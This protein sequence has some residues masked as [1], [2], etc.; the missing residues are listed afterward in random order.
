MK[1]HA[2]V[3]LATLLLTAPAVGQSRFAD[4]PDDERGYRSFPEERPA[5][6]EAQPSTFRLGLGPV[7]RV[8]DKAADGGLGAALDIGSRAAGARLAGDWVRVGSDQGL[9]QYTAELWVDF[10]SGQRL[11]PVLGAGAGIA[12]LDAENAAGKLEG[13]ALGIGVLRGTLEYVLPIAEA[14]ARAGL[15]VQGCLPAVRGSRAPDAMGWLLV[16]AR[17]GVGF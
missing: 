1:V 16:F 12:R 3:A 6:L 11:H 4:A 8:T 14:D 13:H 7:L 17:V 2:K 9:S 10:G 15:D 5:P